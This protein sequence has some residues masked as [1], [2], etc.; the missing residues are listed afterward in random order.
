M[1]NKVIIQLNLARARGGTNLRSHTQTCDKH[2]NV[3]RIRFKLVCDGATCHQLCFRVACK[4]YFPPSLLC[5]GI[6]TG[7]CSPAALSICSRINFSTGVFLLHLWDCC[8]SNRRDVGSR[9]SRV[10]A[11]TCNPACTCASLTPQTQCLNDFLF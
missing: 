3:H 2:L 6:I 4:L 9:V 10:C 7:V 11:D 5:C 1:N 8:H